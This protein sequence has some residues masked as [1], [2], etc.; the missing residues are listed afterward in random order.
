[1]TQSPCIIP[2]SKQDKKGKHYASNCYSITIRDGSGTDL[3]SKSHSDFVDWVVSTAQFFVIS[4][5]KEGKASH[6]QVGTF[7]ASPLRQDYLRSKIMEIYE[8]L[9]WTE[10]Q[11]KHAVKVHHHNNA[12]VLFAYCV[13][14]ADP[15]QFK[16]PLEIHRLRGCHCPEW[17]GNAICRGCDPNRVVLCKTPESRFRWKWF[18]TRVEYNPELFFTTLFLDSYKDFEPLYIPY[19]PWQTVTL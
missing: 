7:F 13:K 16:F 14:E 18:W 3:G 19:H 10:Q 17:K 11:K 6:F 2:I 8:P 5:E 12:R 15:L 9:N 1:M 4:I